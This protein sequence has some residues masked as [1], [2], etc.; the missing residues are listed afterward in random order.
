MGRERRKAGSMAFAVAAAVLCAA[1]RDAGAT[2][3]Q[4]GLGA[5]GTG[6]AWRGDGGA[7]GTGRLGLRLADLIAIYTL[8]RFGFSAVDQRAI[9]FLSLGVQVYGKLGDF[10][11]FG[12]IAGAH[13]HEES[14]A[15]IEQDPA[16][17]LFGIGDGIRHRA[18]GELGAGADLHLLQ[19]GSVEVVGTGELM[20]S[21]FPDPRGP[22][23]YLGGAVALG[24]NYDI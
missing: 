13:Q 15:A 8:E 22:A 14:V 19:Q 24:I 21:Y 12:R 1:P 6:S 11:P 4:L 7:H 17:V 5:A 20:M 2:E 18:G 3:I 9:T 23:W 16:G 10:R